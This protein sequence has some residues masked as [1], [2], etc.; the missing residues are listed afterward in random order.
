MVKVINCPKKVLFSISILLVL[1][2]SLVSAETVRFS[3]AGTKYFN[4]TTT[5]EQ[6]SDFSFLVAGEQNASSYPSNIT[7]DIGNDGIIDWEYRVY[8]SNVTIPTTSV[9]YASSDNIGSSSF[10]F[11]S[12]ALDYIISMFH[13]GSLDSSN[14]FGDNGGNSMQDGILGIEAI[15]AVGTNPQIITIV[16]NESTV[17]AFLPDVAT[18]DGSIGLYVAGGGSTYYCASF[19]EPLPIGEDPLCNVAPNSLNNTQLARVA[20]QI[21]FNYSET[22]RNQHALDSINEILSNCPSICNITVKVTSESAGNIIINNLNFTPQDAGYPPSNISIV[23]NATAYIVNIQAAPN[24]ESISYFYGEV[25]NVYIIPFQADDET[26]TLSSNQITRLNLIKNSLA[27]SWD[28]LTNRSHPINFTFYN[29]TNISGLS[30]NDNYSIFQEILYGDFMD[31]INMTYPAILVTVDIWDYYDNDPTNYLY[32]V[33]NQTMISHIYFN[34][35]ND[36]PAVT[37]DNY[38]S[39]IMMNV[40]LHELMHT[41]AG[42]P[43]SMI[44]GDYVFYGYHPASFIDS[45]DFESV[46]PVA[47]SSSG[48]E[49]YYEIYSVMNPIRIY[50]QMS[51]LG[52]IQALLSPLDKML[53]G[54]LSPDLS[55]NY[56]FYNGGIAKVGNSFQLTGLTEAH[57]KSLKEIY[58]YNSDN[59]WWDVRNNTNATEL[60]T[61]TSFFISKTGQS[62]RSLWVF[63][64]DSYNKNHFRVFNNNANSLVSYASSSQST[65]DNIYPIF[66]NFI[67]NNAT[68]NGSGIARFN[69]TINKTNGTVLLQINNVNYTAKN[70]TGNV[71][72]VSISLSN[73]TYL[74]KWI[75][76]GNGSSHN[77]NISNTRSYTVNNTLA[78]STNTS[79]DNIYPIFYNYQDNSETLIDSGLALFSVRVNKTNGTVILEINGANYTALNTSNIYNVSLTLTGGTYNYRWIAYG[80]GTQKNQNLSLSR[81]YIVNVSSP[82]EDNGGGRGGGGGRSRRTNVTNNQTNASVIIQNGTKVILPSDETIQK[83]PA[84]DESEGEPSINDEVPEKRVSIIKVLMMVSIFIVLAFCIIKIKN[85]IHYFSLI[86]NV[87]KEN[88]TI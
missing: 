26:R 50:L 80:N 35:M 40:L 48:E 19:H 30:T 10:N 60:G 66:Y 71:Y 46:Y 21:Y 59:I 55:Y 12:I 78:N 18:Y 68:L 49:G 76:F 5:Y 43:L 69:V 83:T 2:L 61:Q 70:L 77:M 74:Y 8:H 45:P 32:N 3:S 38:N 72:N 16:T 29:I 51:E 64:R 6:L 84:E 73:G 34:G 37:L 1:S 52:G 33:Y 4:I 41:F 44:N 25:P 82:S 86:K 7:I 88:A 79:L 39:E 28:A 24:L 67:D 87:Q 9:S 20:D 58:P 42:Y 14:V 27:S 13:F 85:I 56:T 62:N 22:V 47:D 31:N 63:A 81:I 75:A 57:T 11:K 65:Q 23:E 54:I 15:S 36:N 17:H 53:L